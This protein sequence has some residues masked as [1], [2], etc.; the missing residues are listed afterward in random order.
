MRQSRPY[1]VRGGKLFRFTFQGRKY[2]SKSEGAAWAKLRKLRGDDVPKSA[3]G[4]PPTT[5][6]GAVQRWRESHG[7]GWNSNMLRSLRLWAG[8]L[9]LDRVDLDFLNRFVRHL[10]SLRQ[11]KSG[12]PYSRETIYKHVAAATSLMQWAFRRKWIAAV[13]DRPK[14]RRGE[15][16]PEPLSEE[17]IANVLFSL[18]RKDG[19]MMRAGR[20]IKFML[21]T[22]ARPQE[23]R[24]LRWE[25]IDVPRACAIIPAE[26]TKTRNSSPRP[27]VLELSNEALQ[28]LAETP[29]TS[30]YV[31]LSREGKPYTRDGL[32]RICNSRKFRPYQLRQT[33]TQRCFDVGLQ[34]AVIAALLGHVDLKMLKHYRRV[35]GAHARSAIQ[36]VPNLPLPAALAK[37]ENETAPSEPRKQT[38]RSKKR[39]SPAAT[40]EQPPASTAR[41]RASGGPG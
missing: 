24:L 15:A 11:K 8:D 4:P 22:G 34:D 7:P 10:E 25:W 23:A 32:R 20:I 29:R 1:P 40:P 38:D 2:S 5:I 36:L 9:D 12:G 28:V 17:Q 39:P 19:T 30:P 37:P 27:R 14:L 13:P 16:K 33:F 35:T 18:H 3:G 6:S 41:R 21:L 31:F 26:E